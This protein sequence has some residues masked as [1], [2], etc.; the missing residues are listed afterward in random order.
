MSNISKILA[1]DMCEYF[2]SHPRI[3]L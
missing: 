3:R 2:R 1:I